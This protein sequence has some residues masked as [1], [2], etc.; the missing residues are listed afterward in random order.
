MVA[1]EMSDV[2]SLG[3]PKSINILFLLVE[4]Q[5]SVLFSMV[6]LE[7]ETPCYVPPLPPVFHDM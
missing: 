2:R 4:T 3:L 5:L 7:I 6:I 1:E